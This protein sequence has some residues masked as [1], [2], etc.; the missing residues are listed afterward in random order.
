MGKVETKDSARVVVKAWDEDN[1]R[2]VDAVKVA[3]KV[4][5]RDVSDASYKRV[6]DN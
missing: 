4:L 6:L 2:V 1:A 3:G 5:E